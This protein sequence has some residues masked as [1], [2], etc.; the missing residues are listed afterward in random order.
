MFTP[1]PSSV[2]CCSNSYFCVYLS[3]GCRDRRD[4]VSYYIV[5]INQKKLT[6]KENLTPAHK[7][8]LLSA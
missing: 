8:V 6:N 4:Q 1:L 5:E 2:L 7:A 3:D